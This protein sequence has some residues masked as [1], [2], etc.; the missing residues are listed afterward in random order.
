MAFLLDP[1]VAY[2]T[3][4]IAFLLTVFAILTPGT[5]LFEV[6]AAF[7][8]LLAGWQVYNLPFNAWSLV[9]VVLAGLF[10]LLAL[11][12]RKDQMVY[13]AASVVALVVGSVFL[14][15][16]ETLWQPAVNPLVA[17]IVSAL[18][19]A[20]FWVY[21]R[22]AIEAGARIPSHDLGGLV[23]ALGEARTDVQKE[24]SVY[25][26]GEMWTARSPVLIPRGARVR[27][28]RRE[29]FVLDVEPV[30]AKE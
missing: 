23:G 14:F 24:G 16:G 30:E 4:V 19:G 5:G 9:I 10:F 8:L 1:N 20:L 27:V 11:R 25:I 12:R 26:S 7:A 28:T 18:A 3:L 21:S 15:H 2:L 6:G 13:L 29:G 22:K 17:V